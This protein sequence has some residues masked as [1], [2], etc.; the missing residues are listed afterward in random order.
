MPPGFLEDF[1]FRFADEGLP[2]LVTPIGGLARWPG[3]AAPASAAVALCRWWQ[4]KAGLDVAV[5]ASRAPAASAHTQPCPP[6][7]LHHTPLAR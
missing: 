2:S 4:G 1:A 7:L 3:L 6:A 5:H